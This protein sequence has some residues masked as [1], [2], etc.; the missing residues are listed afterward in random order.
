MSHA[1]TLLRGGDGALFPLPGVHRIVVE[2]TWRVDGRA[3]TASGETS[4][5]V[6]GPE[7]TEHA[8]AAHRMLSV[9]NAMLTMVLGGDHLRDGIDT[10]HR[11]LDC[12]QLNEHVA[13]IEAKRLA[14]P[15]FERPARLDQAVEL[16]DEATVM[17]QAEISR[18]AD[19]VKAM[20]PETRV[21]AVAGGPAG[22]GPAA[23]GL[24]A[25]GFADA[26]DA[27]DAIA[28]PAATAA[29]EATDAARDRLTAILQAKVARPSVADDVRTEVAAL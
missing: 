9:P 1:V 16:L 5:I 24:A 23:I 29:D 6:T 7:T 11:A 28:A 13:W 2:V 3:V 26:A 10:I 4:V 15:F 19:I 17:S 27:A 14:T 25:V 8:I 21:G 20:T 22:G 12:A 18:A